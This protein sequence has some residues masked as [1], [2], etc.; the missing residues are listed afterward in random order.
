MVL[1]GS[2]RAEGLASE[3]LSFGSPTDRLPDS[4]LQASPGLLC[5][6]NEPHAALR[7]RYGAAVDVE[8]AADLY[9]QGWT[10]RQ[11]GAELGFHSSTVSQQL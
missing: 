2:L 8:R 6:P 10:L 3:V 7:P 1:A 9:T 11:I 5:N 4:S